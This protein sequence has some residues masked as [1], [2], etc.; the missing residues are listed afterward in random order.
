MPYRHAPHLAWQLIG[1]EAVVI[2]LAGAKTL[3]LN[4]VASL[5]WSLLPELDE[6]A[7]AREMTKRFDVPLEAAKADVHDFLQTLGEQGL[8]VEA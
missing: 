7:I 6:A 3:G 5:I 2:D 1:G 8:V 4:P